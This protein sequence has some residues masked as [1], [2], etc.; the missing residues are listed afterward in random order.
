MERLVMKQISVAQPVFHGKEQEYVLECMNSTRISSCGKFIDAFERQFAL[1]CETDFALTCNSG[2]AALHLAMLAHDVGPGDEVIV[3]AL[4]Y[5]ATAN[6]VVYCGGTPVFADAEP[7]TG[8]I[9][10]NKIE[11]LINS[12]TRGIIVVHLY[13]H[14]VDMDPIME[15]AE[16]HNLFVVEDAAEALGA[17]YKG[18]KVGSI[19][20]IG[21]FSFSAIKS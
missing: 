9:D 6:A 7:D 4:T 5:I 16:R 17:L 14:P 10:P 20:S 15:I 2:T 11:Q 13:G 19:G 18:R 1:F 8:N 12:R 21:T 3:P